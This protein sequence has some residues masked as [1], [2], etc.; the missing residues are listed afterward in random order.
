MREIPGLR[1][2]LSHFYDDGSK[3]SRYQNV[4]KFVEEELGYRETIDESWRG[5][6]ARY[7]FLTE[8][9]ELPKNAS[10][11]DVGA[12]TG[13]F[14]LSLAWDRTDCFFTAYEPNTAHC[15]FMKTILEHFAIPNV[16]VLDEAVGL[17]QL[18][19]LPGFHTVL[20]LNILH[21]AGVDFDQSLVR[22]REQF[23]G[24]L[25]AYL[26]ALARKCTSLVFQLGYNW[27]GDKSKPLLPVGDV[28]GMIS[29][30]RRAAGESWAITRIGLYERNA[31]LGRYLPVAP[32]LAD[33]VAADSRERQPGLSE[34]Y[35]RPIFLMK[36]LVQRQL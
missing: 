30:V 29:L 4:P 33:Q 19:V 5:D 24:Y 20:L 9:M 18:R 7:A 2:K 27:G 8:N 36:S 6:S 16:R 26:G 11:A 21:H 23:D 13:F 28:A 32:D 3:H 25:A 10:V 12:N 31:G 35:H 22:R 14:T 34:F 15:Q 17:E 1:D